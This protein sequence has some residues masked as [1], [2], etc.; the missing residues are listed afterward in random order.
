[1][2]NYLAVKQNY[3]KEMAT[4]I[5]IV[6]DDLLKHGFEVLYTLVP[7]HVVILGYESAYKMV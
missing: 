4:Q 2:K 1:M 7:A 6:L 3:A 5:Q